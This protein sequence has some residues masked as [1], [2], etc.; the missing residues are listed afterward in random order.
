MRSNSEARVRLRTGSH[1]SGGA[2]YGLRG[3]RPFRPKDST[4]AG[5]GQANLHTQVTDGLYPEAPLRLVVV[6]AAVGYQRRMEKQ[7]CAEFKK[8]CRRNVPKR[9]DVALFFAQRAGASEFPYQFGYRKVL[10]VLKTAA[11][12]EN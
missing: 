4:A 7:I 1:G 9:Q 8:W 2:L 6:S 11:A 3:I 12:F 10:D 5:C